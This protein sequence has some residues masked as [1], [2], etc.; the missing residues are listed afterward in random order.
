MSL[1]FSHSFSQIITDSSN[2]EKEMIDQKIESIAELTDAE[3]DYSDLLE[4]LNYYLEHPVNLNNTTAEELKKLIVLNDIQINNLFEHMN[5]NG[6]L[7]SI[8]E[9]QSIEGFDLE[10]INKLIPYIYVSGEINKRYFSIKEMLKNG[11]N[12]LLLRYQQVIEEQQGFSPILD[13]ALALSP[14]SRYLGSPQSLY[15]KYRF[16]YYNNISIGITAEKDAGEEFFRGSQKKG[17]DFYSAHFYLKDIG[18]IK[19]LAIGDFQAQFGQGLTLWTGL[20]FGKSSDGTGIKKNAQGIS[21]YSS[22]TDNLFLRGAGTT[23]GIKDIELSMFISNKKIDANISSSDSLTHDVQLISSLQQT[24]LHSIPSEIEDKDA[25]RETSAGGHICYKTTRLNLGA[26]A[27]KSIYSATLLRQNEP[28][29]QFQFNGKENSNIG[30]DYSSIF[31]NINLFGEISQSENNAKAFLSGM[32]VSLDPKISLSMLYRNYD[33]RYQALYSSAFAESSTPA[34]EKG[35]YFGI[36]LK[37][38]RSI[39]INAYMDNVTFPWLKYRIEAPSR[40]TDYLV[41][42]NWKP[43]KKIEMY[44]RYRQTNKE[45]NHAD[46]STMF[47]IPVNTPKQNYRFNVSYQV[48]HSLTLKNRIETIYYKIGDGTAQKGF[49]ICQ[50]ISYKKMKSPFS[51]SMRYALFDADSYDCRIYAYE[52]DVLNAY[53]IPALYNKGSRFYITAKYSINIHADIWIR[54]AQTNYSNI[55]VIGSGLTQIDGNTKTE[56]KMQFRFKF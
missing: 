14:N 11:S 6:K 40:A 46:E 19:A 2:T 33:K 44:A 24:G 15:T 29:N 52:N 16:T 20:G 23:I 3:L 42:V 50:D 7:I 48:S 21:P 37:P 8:Y 26:T 54:F 5:K 34:N 38:V 39:T 17:F 56:I 28:Y 18:I 36:L 25:I 55:N 10:T 41:Q 9:L 53:S 4:N 35:I 13:S 1:F 27:F 12:Q 45:L 31:K 32:L 22:V 47:Y 30:F 49:F 43:S 51:F